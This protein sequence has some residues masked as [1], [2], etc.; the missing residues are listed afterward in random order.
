VDSYD[1]MWYMWEL[2][3]LLLKFI[4]AST[5]LWFSSISRINQ[6]RQAVFMMTFTLVCSLAR[7][8]PYPCF[9]CGPYCIVVYTT[10]MD[11]RFLV[12]PE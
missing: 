8:Y 2:Q 4:M 10:R 7:R 5:L 12:M 6:L 9:H 3:N 11:T 1:H